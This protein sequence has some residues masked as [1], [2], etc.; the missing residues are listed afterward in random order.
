MTEVTQNIWLAKASTANK[1]LKSSLLG[2]TCRL[3]EPRPAN[4]K[5]EASGSHFVDFC[6]QSQ[7]M[8]KSSLLELIL[9]TS[10]A[11][12]RK[13]QNRCLWN[14]CCRLPEPMPENAQMNPSGTPFVDD[15]SQGQKMLKLDLLEFV[16]S[17]SGAEARKC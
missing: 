8:L 16:L 2:L 9:D 17:T 12:A 1:I 4:V 5:I 13:W 11:K 6:L 10:R 3:L 14:S 15:W 7:R